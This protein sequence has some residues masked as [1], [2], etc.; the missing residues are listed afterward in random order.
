MTT[1]GALVGVLSACVLAVFSACTSVA[2]KPDV[3]VFVFAGQSNMVGLGSLG[4]TLPSYLTTPRNDALFWDVK[5]RT[6]VTVPPTTGGYYGPEVS[7]LRGLADRLHTRVLGVKVA[8]SGTSLA[9]EWDPT[10][11]PGL[12]AYMK[13]TLSDALRTSAFGDRRLKVAGFFWM[14]GES[15]ALQIDS[16]QRYAVN[17]KAFISHVRHDLLSPRLPFII[18]RIQVISPA[19][20]TGS[21]IVRAAEDAAALHDH[22]VRT[23]PTDGVSRWPDYHFDGPGLIALGTSFADAYTTIGR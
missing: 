9:K 10:L 8:V 15:D 2:A 21:D 3:P 5:A 13:M 7:A 19:A 12:Y 1:T 22:D 6:W 16:A 4:S 20:V 17:L 11:K 18:G 14:Q 23:V